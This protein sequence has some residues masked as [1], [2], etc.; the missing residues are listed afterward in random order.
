M[1]KVTKGTS[2][3]SGQGLFTICICNLQK[4]TGLILI[5]FDCKGLVIFIRFSP[6][7]WILK[8]F[9]LMSIFFYN[10]EW[11]GWFSNMPSMALADSGMSRK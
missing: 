6:Y 3:C 8:T 2:Y 4:N 7:M 1:L 11:E 9:F 10:A 5:I